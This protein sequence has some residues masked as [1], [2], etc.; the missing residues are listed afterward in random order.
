MTVME[1]E[2][3]VSPLPATRLAYE[4]VLRGTHPQSVSA[5]VPSLTWTTLPILHEPLVLRDEQLRLLQ[6]AIVEVRSAYDWIV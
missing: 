2:L 1:R 4:A 6:Q 5:I 3:G